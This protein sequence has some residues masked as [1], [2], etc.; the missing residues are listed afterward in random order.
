MCQ[1]YIG[2]ALKTFVRAKDLTL[3]LLTFSKGG[4]PCMK[5][6]SLSPLLGETTRFAM[7]GSAISPEFSIAKELWQCDFDENQIA[8]VIDNL[9]I[10]A[11]QAMPNGGSLSI[12]AENVHIQKGENP[13]SLKA[14]MYEFR[15]RIRE[16]DTPNILPRIF[17]PFFSTKQ[18]GNGLG[19]AIA[20]SI[21]KST[22]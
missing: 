11:M 19:L 21:M 7:S 5:T 1:E 9:V 4:A 22:G 13:P 8:Q 15:S 18:Q 17:D 16:S 10:N 2:K 20:Y 3:Q 12:A 6:G 14:G